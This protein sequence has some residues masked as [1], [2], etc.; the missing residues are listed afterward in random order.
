MVNNG[1]VEPAPAPAA[2]ETPRLTKREG[3]SPRDMFLS[4]AVLLVPIA[5]LMLFYRVVLDGDEPISK[6][7]APSFEQ[8][9]REF[10]VLEPAGLGD[11]WKVASASFRREDGG[12]TLR[13]GYVTPDGGAVQLVESTVASTTLVPAQLGETGE[14]T[15]TFRSGQR[16]WM[17]Y[18]GRKGETALVAT[19]QNVTYIVL[20]SVDRPE[21]VQQLATALG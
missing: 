17:Q 13:V 15:G 18:S 2:P 9:A 5:L 21:N 12:A 3:R 8:A 4:L 20:G 6:D 14:R 10:A 7:A 1:L 16:A 11:D 19:E